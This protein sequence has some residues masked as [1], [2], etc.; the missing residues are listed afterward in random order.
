MHLLVAGWQY[1]IIWILPYFLLFYFNI[2]QL[3]VNLN[4]FGY[5]N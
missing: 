5:A 4:T 2:A 1:S 3:A